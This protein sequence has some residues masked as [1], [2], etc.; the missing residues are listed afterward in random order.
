MQERI[1][2]IE[3]D[4]SFQLEAAISSLRFYWNLAKHKNETI[5]FELWAESGAIVPAKKEVIQSRN[6]V[7]PL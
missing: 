6:L 2:N 3:I 5:A 1:D 7:S 4:S